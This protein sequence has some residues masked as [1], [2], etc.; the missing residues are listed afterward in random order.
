MTPTRNL[1]FRNPPRLTVRGSNEAYRQMR[2]GFDRRPRRETPT[3]LRRP[4]DCKPRWLRRPHDSDMTIVV[5][6]ICSRRA[7]RRDARSPCLQWLPAVRGRWLARHLRLHGKIRS[8]A[9]WITFIDAPSNLHDTGISSASRPRHALRQPPEQSVRCCRCCVPWSPVCR[10]YVRR[11]AGRRVHT[12]HL[13]LFSNLKRAL[14]GVYRCRPPPP[15]PLFHGTRLQIE[16]SLR[17]GIEDKQRM[18]DAV[19]G[20]EGKRPTTVDLMATADRVQWRNYGR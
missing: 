14:T 10:Q 3:S 6:R 11:H 9:R 8:G 18:I 5:Q 2:L 13:G 12:H 7:A 4:T 1:S 16:P 17:Q 19:M 15:A 20:I